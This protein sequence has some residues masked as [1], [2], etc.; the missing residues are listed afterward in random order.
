M[1]TKSIQIF[2]IASTTLLFAACGGGSGDASTAAAA[3]RNPV[4]VLTA[5]QQILTQHP[6]NFNVTTAFSDPDGDALSYQLALSNPVPGVSIVGTSVVGTPTGDNDFWVTGMVRDGKG[7]QLNVSIPFQV[8]MNASPVLTVPPSTMLVNVGTV[9]SHDVTLGGTMFSE[10]DGDPISYQT[11]L[12]PA[13]HGLSVANNVVTGTFQDFGAVR[14]IVTASDTYGGNTTVSFLI[15]AP[16]P[17]PQPGPS[18]PATP[19]VYEDLKLPLPQILL[20]TS[21]GARFLDTTRESNQPTDAGATL[22]RVLFFDKRLSLTNTHSCSSCHKPEHGFADAQRF[23]VGV[24]GEPTKR[25]VMGL[26]NARYNLWGRYFSDERVDGLEALA[27]LPIQEQTELGNTMEALIPK[28]SATTYYPALFQAAFGTQEITADRI[29]RALAQFIRSLISYRARLDI[30]YPTANFFD[31]AAPL[32]TAQ[33][34]AG[35]AIFAANCAICHWARV[36]VQFGAENNGLDAVPA[37]LGAGFGRFR[38]PSLRNVARTAPYMHDGRFA[39]LRE[40]IEHYDNGVVASESLAYALRGSGSTSARRLNL[41]ESE[42]IALEVFLN[43]GTD[44]AMLSDP[45]FQDPF[46]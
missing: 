5:P 30:A 38:T 4:Q 11:T 21:G 6:L 20:P 32:L 23:S 43:A 1:T 42:K 12:S 40:V 37:D 18:L 9:V 24:S 39:T 13:G 35:R 25:N 10:S 3:N 22:G 45:K 36:Q 15:A 34:N 8:S 27:L 7:G 2:L 26:T 17:L 19:Y 41:T 14:V 16:A 29:A 31:E 28:L 44:D 33:E 46:R